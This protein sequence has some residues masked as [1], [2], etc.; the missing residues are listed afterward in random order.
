MYFLLSYFFFMKQPCAGG[1][2]HKLLVKEGCLASTL[3]TLQPF[4]YKGYVHDDEIELYYLR[5][6]Y[7]NPKW[8]GIVIVKYITNT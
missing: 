4:Q 3:G 1:C 6:R 2:E 8:G 5:N 7:Y